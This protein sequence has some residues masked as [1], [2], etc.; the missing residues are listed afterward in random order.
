M[1]WLLTSLF[2]CVNILPGACFYLPGIAPIDYKKGAKLDVK[3]GCISCLALTFVFV[4]VH[5][6]VDVFDLQISHHCKRNLMDVCAL[7][8]HLLGS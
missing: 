4:D 7:I 8:I 6:Y 1:L 2:T 5:L 3:V